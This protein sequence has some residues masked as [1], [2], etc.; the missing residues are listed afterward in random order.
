M[1]ET[2]KSQAVSSG[3]ADPGPRRGGHH[4]GRGRDLSGWKGDIDI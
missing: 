1:V 4:T 3:H 2:G